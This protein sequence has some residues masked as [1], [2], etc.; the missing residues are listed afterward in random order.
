MVCFIAE[1]KS[2]LPVLVSKENIDQL[3]KLIAFLDVLNG[4]LLLE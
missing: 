3:L 4:N 2:H 1:D